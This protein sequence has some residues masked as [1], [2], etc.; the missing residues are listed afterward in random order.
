[1]YLGLVLLVLGI[2]LIVGSLTPLLVVPI[3]ALLVDRN[4]IAVEERIL[5]ERFG[6]VWLAYKKRV[7]RWM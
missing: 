5:E 4:F 3:F 7:R 6:T 2:A 1:M